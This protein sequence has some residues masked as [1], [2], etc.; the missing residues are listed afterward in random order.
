MA[1]FSKPAYKIVLLGKHGA[2]DF[3]PKDPTKD[4]TAIA[5]LSNKTISEL[6]GLK[7]EENPS[8]SEEDEKSA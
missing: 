2:K 1:L 3:G 6:L 4:E 8:N 7:E 5:D